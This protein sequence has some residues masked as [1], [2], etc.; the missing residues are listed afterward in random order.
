MLMRPK[1][2][3]RNGCRN[4]ND[5]AKSKK[6]EGVSPGRGT[7]IERMYNHLTH[8]KLNRQDLICHVFFIVC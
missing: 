5:L 8:L 1:S 4:M 2:W 3:L 6:A 7:N